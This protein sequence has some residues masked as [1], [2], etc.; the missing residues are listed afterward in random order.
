MISIIL[1]TY[2]TS[3]YLEKS[4]FKCIE[5]I[6]V[7]TVLPSEIII[8]DDS[9][10]NVVDKL[11]KTFPRKITQILRY[12][13]NPERLGLS[14][15]FNKCLSIA[16]GEYVH[17]FAQDDRYISRDSLQI[18]KSFISKKKEC[19]WFITRSNNQFQ[20]MSI[21]VSLATILGQNTI[22][23]LSSLVAR[24]DVV[25]M[26]DVRLTQ[27]ADVDLYWRLYHLFGNPSVIPSKTVRVGTHRFQTVRAAN[28]LKLTEEIRHVINKYNFGLES[29]VN[30]CISSNNFVQSNIIAQAIKGT[31]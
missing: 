3:R 27:L 22:G 5:S 12:E 15:N 10:S 8:C 4:L 19:N 16:N 6:A 7:Q 14:G 2:I 23:G 9:N 26:L 30:T 13:K 20:R 29:V 1:P 18:I 28:K 21:E 24:R 17:F 31:T 11:R 25:P